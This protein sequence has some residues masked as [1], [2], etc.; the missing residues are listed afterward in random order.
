VDNYPNTD[1]DGDSNADADA[2]VNEHAYP[3]LR[4]WLEQQRHWTHSL[5]QQ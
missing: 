2:N 5:L 1:A 3:D 4:S